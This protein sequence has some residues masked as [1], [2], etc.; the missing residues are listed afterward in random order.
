ML[1]AL[2]ADVLLPFEQQQRM[3]SALTQGTT[4]SV[5]SVVLVMALGSQPCNALPSYALSAIRYGS[6]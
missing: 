6:L 1:P 2:C 4:A 5:E 3:S